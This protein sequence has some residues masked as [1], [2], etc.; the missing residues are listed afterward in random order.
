MP[1][2]AAKLLR[3]IRSTLGQFAASAIVVATGITAF[4]AMTAVSDNLI[5][6]RDSFYRETEFADHFFHVV[7]APEGILSRIE[8][9]NG[10]LK[11]T[12]RIQKDVPVLSGDDARTNLRLVGYPLPAE[13]ELS[14]IMVLKGR[15]FE[16]YPEGGAVEVVLNPQFAKAHGLIP[17]DMLSIAAEGRRKTLSITGTAAGPEF[18][19]AVKNAASLLEDPS[20]FGVAILPQ[21]QIQQLLEMK[22]SI[23]QILIRFVPGAD[24]AGVVRDIEQILEPY[25]NLANY[26][27]KD[28]LSDAVLSGELDQLRAFARFLP[29]V[30]LGVAVLMQFVFIGRMVQVQRGQ[31]G[32]L[33]AL[34]YGN[35]ALL[36]LY[37]GYALAASATGASAGTFLGYVLAQLLTR[38]YAAFFNLPRLDEA[39][40][41][42]AA[43]VVFLATLVIGTAAG[44]WAARGVLVI[45]PAE[46][47][48]P[49]SPRPVRPMFFEKIPAFSKWLNLHWR[50][51][52]RSM[53]R[54]RFRAAV[55]TLGILFAVGLLVVS[56]FSRDSMDDLMVRH[57]EKEW[58]FDYLVRILDPVKESDLLSISRL[59]G[60]TEAEPIFELPVRFHFRGR[61]REDI[62]F[63]MHPGSGLGRVITLDGREFDFPVEGLFL[64]WYAA[65]I[66]GAETGDD[67]EV[68]TILGLGPPRRTSVRVVGISRKA[69][70]GASSTS[71]AV[72]N[73]LLNEQGT[74]SGMVLRVDGLSSGKFEDR[75]RDMINVL[76]VT[77]RLKEMA[78]L[79]KNL[80][81]LY[82][83]V[84]VMVIFSV[85]LGFAIVFNASSLSFSERRRELASLRVLGFSIGEVASF[86]WKENLLLLAAGTILGLPFGK[87]LSEAY[88]AGVSTDLFTFEAVIY[89]LTYALAA[90]G[91]GLFILVSWRLAVGGVRNLEPVETLKAKD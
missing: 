14:R 42:R 80:K 74:A 67:I 60:V 10:V 59:P 12:G 57:F 77:D 40:H 34:G 53:G 62:L 38:V 76:S 58:R 35:G 72:A 19:Y 25:G 55:T 1:V 4:V 75:L 16:K 24:E 85:I 37:G 20:S 89:P 82:Y 83:S 33:K 73:R 51:S 17:G 87:M 79:D 64:D 54:N 21:N 5:R 69:F 27:R 7:L 70:G 56:V 44:I 47:M 36:A 23:N 45:R 41:F 32:L 26:P 46:S 71:L 39:I 31:I 52:L 91:G 78:Y 11:A 63:A 49:A 84:G 8:A 48:R 50:M 13:G 66:L 88:A 65:G 61:S 68:E 30:F 29:S 86:L 22:G 9:V 18:V 81:Y 28:Q 90:L 3:T 43:A 2:L 6:S 15:L